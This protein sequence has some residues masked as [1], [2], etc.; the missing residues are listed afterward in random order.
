MSRFAVAIAIVIAVSP[1]AAAPATVQQDIAE[2]EFLYNKCGTPLDQLAR[3]TNERCAAAYVLR[4]KLLAQGYCIFDYGVVGRFSKDK[5][6]CY[7]IK[8][9][10]KLDACG[11]LFWG[12]PEEIARAAECRRTGLD[13]TAR[14]PVLPMASGTQALSGPG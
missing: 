10:N 8:N 13:S 1:A 12:P 9:P 3:D 7:E 14:K 5:K 6:H 11:H 2:F 4:K